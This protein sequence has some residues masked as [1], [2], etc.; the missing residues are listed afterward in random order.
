MPV[1]EWPEPTRSLQILYILVKSKWSLGVDS[2][3]LNKFVFEGQCVSSPLENADVYG[4]FSL[5]ANL[6]A[7]GSSTLD[8]ADM[9]FAGEGYF[10]RPEYVQKRVPNL[11][12]TLLC[13]ADGLE[14]VY[15]TFL[16]AFAISENNANPLALF[17]HVEPPDAGLGGS[18]D[19]P[20]KDFS[21]S[22]GF[23]GGPMD[24]RS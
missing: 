21:H 19:H 13:T 7:T 14:W 2:R 24:L 17:L 11:N 6:P 9:R 18:A 22:S 5:R 8:S 16:G 23:S 10:Y 15:R 1:L 3:S 20:V 4:E 12:F